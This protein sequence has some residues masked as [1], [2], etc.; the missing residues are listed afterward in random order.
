MNITILLT[1]ILLFAGVF[2]CIMNTSTARAACSPGIPCTEYDL[3]NDSDAGTDSSKN[4]LKTD[5]DSCD[6]NL[7]NRIYSKAYMEASRQ[8]ITAEH[9]I[10]KPDSVLEYTCFDQFVSITAKKAGTIF[11][12]SQDWEEVTM[13][14][15]TADE[16]S[17]KD[18]SVAF[19]VGTLEDDMEPLI[20]GV[21]KNYIETNFWHDFLGGFA[22][23]VNNSMN[24]DSIG[25]SSY[26]CAHMETIWNIA[27][28]TDFGEDDLFWTYE[29]L[30]DDDPRTLPESCS[31]STTET[32]FSEDL[33]LLAN[34]SP[35]S[36]GN[37][38]YSAFD[39][40]ALQDYLILGVNDGTGKYIPG[41]GGDTDGSITCAAPIPTGIPIVTYMHDEDTYT[42]DT[43]YAQYYTKKYIH[44]EYM[45]PNPGCYY[46][47]V[48][49]SLGE[50]EEETPIPERKDIS[51]GKCVRY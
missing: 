50:V 43:G 18:Y 4:G 7:M 29:D 27:K 36:N 42:E 10:H 19:P 21:L 28:C 12:E 35:T 11:S 31:S 25:G 49:E 23:G 17:T 2:I 39:T 8:I 1:N 33:I 45:C 37:A 20:Y 14:I 22:T 46:R 24:L 32:N 5:G 30:I 38:P 9:L 15:E 34:N 16:T 13:N 47:P 26:N 51:V 6:G 44:Y 40:I 3:Y 41:T 48:K